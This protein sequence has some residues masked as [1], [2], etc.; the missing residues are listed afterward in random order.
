[1]Q[2][3]DRLITAFIDRRETGERFNQWPPHITL[4]P[5][6]RTDVASD[7]LALEI[8]ATLSHIRPFAVEIG[9]EERFGA[10]GRKLVNL[11]NLP[12][13]LEIIEEAARQVLKTHQAWLVDESTRLR[14]RFRP[15]VTVQKSGRVQEGDSFKCDRLYLVMQ[16]GSSKLITDEV[17]LHG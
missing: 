12:S 5:W 11:V 17:L 15:H 8:Q 10:R 6:F 14:H 3:G 9:Q 16:E 13:P 7:E 2:P 1:M 4:I